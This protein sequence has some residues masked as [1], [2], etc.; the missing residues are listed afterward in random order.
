[1][2][3]FEPW[4]QLKYGLQQPKW[5]LF[6]ASQVDENAFTVSQHKWSHPSSSSNV[7][8]AHC[9]VESKYCAALMSSHWDTTTTLR[10]LLVLTII[11][12]INS[13]DGC[14]HFKADMI[15]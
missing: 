2:T 11:L 10:T 4:H 8:T 14:K 6:L 3:V 12:F 9:D 13:S 15:P 7:I 1:M 5:A